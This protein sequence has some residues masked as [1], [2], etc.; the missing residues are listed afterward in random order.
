MAREYQDC[1][2]VVAQAEGRQVSQLIGAVAH[3]ASDLAPCVVFARLD[4]PDEW[5][6]FFLQAQI[7]FWETWDDNTIAEE[8]DDYKGEDVRLVDY[9]QAVGGLPLRIKSAV[10]FADA[11]DL[12]HI[13]ILFDNSRSI[14][15]SPDTRD[16]DSNFHI[17]PSCP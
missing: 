11:E 7:A 9:A 12:T 13:R 5:H 3:D 1:N 10:A 2:F 17:V 14:T 8:M 4:D 15:L 6:R 16:I